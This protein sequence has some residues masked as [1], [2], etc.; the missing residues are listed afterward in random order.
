MKKLIAGWLIIILLLANVSFSYAENIRMNSSEM[1]ETEAGG[2]ILI[3]FVGDCSIGDSEQYKTASTSYHTTLDEKGYAWPFSLVKHYL[4]ADDLTV[5]NLEVV[6]TKRTQHSDKMYN[7]IGDPDHVQ[8]LIEGSIEMVN[9]VNNHCMDFMQAG[10]Q[11]SIDIL[12]E[13]GI[14]RF[15]TVYP[16]REYG[17]DD[18]GIRD[19]G[20]IRIGFIGFSYPQDSDQKRIATRIQKLKEEE[21]CDLVVVSLHWGRETHMTPEA[22]QVAYAKKVIDAGADLIWGHHPHVIQPIQFYKGKPIL[23]STGNFTFGTM[24]HVDPSTGIFQV[25]YEKLDGTVQLKKLQVIPCETQ[26]T[27]D[28]RPFE[29]TEEAARKGVFK[30]LVWKKVYKNCVNPPD[31]FLNTGIIY[32]EN[33]EML[34]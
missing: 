22:W 3:S 18:L 6:F 26:G 27:S 10:Y 13:A 30:E 14:A 17:Y 33:G 7:L 2:E 4:E 16:G 24:S 5:A 20:E 28:F 31:S 9:T 29:L 23:Y 8:V 32:F 15:G 1:T 21:G 19:I 12:D 11:D 25:T 34:P